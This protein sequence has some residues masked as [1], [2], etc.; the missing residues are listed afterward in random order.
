MNIG[1]AGLNLIKTSEGLRLQ[2]YKDIAGKSTIGYGH[3]ILPSESDTLITITLEEA[4]EILSKD[5]QTVV[6]FLNKKNISLTQNQFDALC[7]FG[8]NLGIGSLT[9]LLAHGID[10]IPQQ[11]ILWDHAGAAVSTGL[12]TRREAEL[13]LWNS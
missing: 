12:K 8:F 5:V 10:Q 11:I 13:T 6:N 1:E 9:K 4:S 3:L 2:R 7:D